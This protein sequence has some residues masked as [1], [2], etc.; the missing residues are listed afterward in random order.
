MFAVKTSEN[1]TDI[2]NDTIN[3]LQELNIDELEAVRSIINVI[4]RKEDNY[5]KPL[6]EAELI[7]RVDKSLAL[8]HDGFA[9]DAEE[10]GKQIMETYGL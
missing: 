7:A 6:T 3:M 2:L 9:M 4:V 10:F 1:K 8:E 5:Y